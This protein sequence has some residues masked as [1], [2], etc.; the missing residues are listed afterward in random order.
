MC[1]T[2]RL[3]GGFEVMNKQMSLQFLQRAKEP[4]I[5]SRTT[6]WWIIIYR[7]LNVEEQI[8][9]TMIWR[10]YRFKCKYESICMYTYMY[11]S[12]TNALSSAWVNI[13]NKKTSTASHGRCFHPLSVQWQI[14]D[15]AA[16]RSQ[17]SSFPEYPVS[18]IKSYIGRSGC[19]SSSRT[20]GKKSKRFVMMG[21]RRCMTKVIE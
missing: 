5:I 4:H 19:G 21:T 17:G 11:M 10:V 2:S 3:D 12:I 20:L 14:S 8:T 9:Y 1:S 15:Q 16:V 18:W 6:Y 13:S 7:T